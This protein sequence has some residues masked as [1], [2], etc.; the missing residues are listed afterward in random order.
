[1]GT[2]EVQAM[3]GAPLAWDVEYY[4][5]KRSEIAR[6]AALNYFFIVV[7]RRSTVSIVCKTR[8]YTIETISMSTSRNNGESRSGIEKM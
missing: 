4:K 1:M 7:L 3:G 6:A 2:G 5:V 8:L